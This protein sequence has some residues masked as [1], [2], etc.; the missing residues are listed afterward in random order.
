MR[1]VGYARASTI[2]DSSLDVQEHALKEAGCELIFIEHEKSSEAKKEFRRCMQSLK[3][4][5]TLVVSQLD[6]LGQTTKQLLKVVEELNQRKIALKIIDLNID[7]NTEA[8]NNFYVILE[9]LKIMEQCL[10]KERTYISRNAAKA[11]GRNGG[12]KPVD[13]RVVEKAIKMYAGNKSVSEITEELSISRTTFY[14]Y[15]KEN[16]QIK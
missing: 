12:R 13:Q 9:G 5:D 3:P 11:R 10:L 15:L 8:G 2:I 16:G 6:R 1:R 14:K 4:N 7:T